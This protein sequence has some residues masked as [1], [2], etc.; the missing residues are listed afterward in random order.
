MD[1]HQ[2]TSP[3]VDGAA[4]PPPAVLVGDLGPRG[5]RWSPGG[6]LH[7]IFEQTCDA[8]ETQGHHDRLAV[9]AEGQQVSY[10][11]LDAGANQLAHLLRRRGVHQGAR[12]AVLCD[13]PLANYTALLAALKAGAAYVPLDTVFPADRIEYVLRDADVELVVTTSA[14]RHLACAGPAAVLDLDEAAAE[15][16]AEDRRRPVPEASP[17]ADALGY[18]VYTSGTT[19]RP[20]GVAVGHSAICHFVRVAA[21]CY[22]VRADDR[23]YQGLTIAFDFSVEEIWLAWAVGATLVPRPPGRS[24]VGEDLHEYL[25]R[26]RVTA[27]CCV[28]TLLTTLEEDLPDLRF[29][30]VSGEACP[31]DLVRRWHRPGR[32]FL[33]VYGPTETTVTATWTPVSPD[34]PVTLGRPLP[35]YSV[36]VLAPDDGRALPPGELGELVIGGVGLARGYLN[37]PDLTARAFVPDPLR[38]PANPAGLVYRTGD[39]A[40]IIDGE[41]EYHGRIDLQVKIRGY[42][43]EL[44]EIESVL[45]EVP[46]VAQAAVAPHEGPGGTEL[47]AYVSLHSGTGP[48]DPAAVYGHLRGRLPTYMVPAYL[49]ELPVLPMTVSDKV[50]R[51]A[52]PPPHGPRS[53][54]AD[55]PYVAP[56]TPLEESL[57]GIVAGALGVDRISV[58]GHLFD[59]LGAN[60]L[61]LA[62]ICARVRERSDL[63]AI[64]IKDV[65]Q[66]PTVR[67]LAA[68]LVG[69]AGAARVTEHVDTPAPVRTRG[70]EYLLCGAVQAAVFLAWS[71]VM[72]V[73]LVRGHEWITVA[74]GALA[75][76]GRAAV[77]GGTAFLVSCLLPIVAKWLLAGRW[78]AQ[79]FPVWSLRY[80]RFWVVKS[81]VRTNP[82][83]L[84]PGSPLAVLHLRALGAR[85]GPRAVV[86][87]NHVPVCSDM[88]TIG[89]GAVVRKDAFLNGYRVVGGVVEIGPVSIGRDAVVG[90]MTVLDV[91]TTI[92]D[93]AEL[94]H[95]SALHAGQSVPPGQRWHGSPA[96]P[97]PVA[98]GSLPPAP[99]GF[100][101]RLVYGTLQLATAAFVWT[102]LLIS[103]LGLLLPE[104]EEIGKQS[105]TDPGFYAGHALLATAL[106]WG[107][108][109][110]GLV[111]AVTLPRLLYRALPADRV[112]RLYG[113]RWSVQRT[114]TRF[115]NL[116]F[117]T[118]LFGDSSAI[119]HW[120]RWIGWD[121]GRVQQTGSNFG[122]AVK[123]EVPGLSAVGP[124]TMV[125]DGL[126]M[127]N[128]D[129]S[130]TSFRVRRTAVGARNYLGNNIAYP[131]GGRT[132]D[133]CLLAT[134]VHVP[135]DGPLRED[136]GLLGSPPFEIPRSVE[137][138]V[139]A[140]PV[141]SRRQRRAA[142][143]E[144]NRHNALTAAL[145][146]IVRWVHFVVAT[147]IFVV[148][149]DHHG[150]LG[151]MVVSAGIVGVLL[152][153]TGFFV[154]VERRFPPRSPL[155]CSIYEPEFW[156]H[157]RYWKVPAMLY[158]EVFNGTPFK[159]L[160]WRALRVRVGRRLFDDGCWITERNLTRVGDDCTWNEG[161]TI[162]S[163][164]LEDGVF[165]SD[166]VVIG[167][168]C[169]LGVG[170]FVHYGATV[171]DGAVLEPD[172]FLM[173][174]ESV[175]ARE[176]WGGNP[177]RLLSVSQPAGPAP[178][179]AGPPAA[180]AALLA[181][182]RAQHQPALP[183]DSGVRVELVELAA[184]RPR[185]E[186]LRALLPACE[187]AA[188]ETMSSAHRREQWIAGRALLRLML[189]SED[190]SRA[191]V[192]WP[193]MRTET[194]RPV[195]P[196][197]PDVSLAHADGVIVAALAHGRAIGVDVE[198]LEHDRDDVVLASALTAEERARLAGAPPGERAGLF[199]RMWTLKEAALKCSGAGLDGGPERVGTALAPARVSGPHVAEAFRGAPLCHQETWARAGRSY[200]LSV[201][202]GDR[203]LPG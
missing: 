42:R 188:A 66:H 92:G 70:V 44:T 53:L 31:P 88:L 64:S 161:G 167:A 199:L 131:A 15:I 26:H 87:T 39:L 198:C 119:V 141:I 179:A 85:I 43:I 104:F 79:T 166:H 12:V 148:A 37:R 138:D 3:P 176:R 175:G 201:V 16:A 155:F 194:D 139:R 178:T 121:L 133:N 147:L 34:R 113:W 17:A 82:L 168:G 102:P 103:A 56:A 124:G 187:Q 52:L 84:F 180:A 162:Q 192:E 90:E 128:A 191:P 41:V 107:A 140:A 174:G 57:A 130:A 54:V 78:R 95:A 152:F 71:Y 72:A 63:P 20:K 50:N 25:A 170:A 126:S 183:A 18:V 5:C 55:G 108:V 13:R 142:L 45:L 117:Y 61:L 132:G 35:G 8:L 100:L 65:Y 125:S 81:L 38:L 4:P 154:L 23:V 28:P 123:H 109:V 101:R 58:N 197:G 7:Q 48:L 184:C 94:A 83:A 98:P 115:T 129:F 10:A 202:T 190:P 69:P 51:A 76:Y 22:G 110:A 9:D 171:G 80:L 159:A 127:L 97:A 74:D 14:T 114:V 30:L 144:K 96:E 173:K 122:M 68:T 185:L 157:E 73:A 62:H 189:S 91:H 172:S 160:V 151:P 67:E 195:V 150:R 158:V 165:K 86:L 6:R 149:I 200:C 32:R 120:L 106:F 134:K 59:D 2:Q 163:H 24:L 135:V 75:S 33:N 1:L 111:A 93:G 40:R 177:A 143:S 193:L 186:E 11:E 181:G 112:F 136:V 36:A 27:L 60:S 89:A 49:E 145:Y 47:V 203:G 146:L 19:G 196:G 153:T 169:T 156:R 29:L 21:E 137:R 164:S 77:F 118:F 105:L 99:C 182:L 116:Q 46:E